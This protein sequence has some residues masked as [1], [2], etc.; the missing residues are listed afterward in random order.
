MMTSDR[1]TRRLQ[2]QI[3][4]P[5]L[6]G[7]SAPAQTS[8]PRAAAGASSASSPSRRRLI[9]ATVSVLGQLNVRRL[10]RRVMDKI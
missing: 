7:P 9:R 6:E 2:G 8:S 4:P 5:L 10:P 1:I 3:L